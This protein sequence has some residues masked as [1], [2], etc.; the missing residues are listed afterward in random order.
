[1]GDKY[2][3]KLILFV[4]DER[5]KFTATLDRL[6][7]EFSETL[8]FDDAPN[9]DVVAEIIETGVTINA[10]VS[11]LLFSRPRPVP[12][13]FEKSRE[14]L[15]LPVDHAQQGF[16]LLHWFQ[17]NRK[18]TKRFMMTSVPKGGIESVDNVDWVETFHPT[19]FHGTGAEAII[20]TIIKSMK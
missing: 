5:H 3:K 7:E 19:D 12:K 15:G 18:D 2:N 1:M 16:I 14:D 10:L 9:L 4:D 17:E 20:E 6:A 13:I 8:L 11:D